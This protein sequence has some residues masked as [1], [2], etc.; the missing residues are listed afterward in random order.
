[1]QGVDALARAEDFRVAVE[2]LAIPHSASR[3]Q[4]V[5]ISIGT[6]CLGPDRRATLETWLSEADK[7]MYEAKSAGR[8]SV[9]A[10]EECLV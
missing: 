6:S 8:N 10:Y 7:A 3:L 5:T 4:R 2:R 9:A 1:M